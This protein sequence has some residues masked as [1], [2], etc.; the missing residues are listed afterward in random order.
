MILARSNLTLLQASCSS[1]L[2]GCGQ[3]GQVLFN[4]TRRLEG[5]AS[6]L[7]LER[8]S[9]SRCIS[10]FGISPSSLEISDEARFKCRYIQL[11]TPTQFGS[12]RGPLHMKLIIKLSLN[13]VPQEIVYSFF[14]AGHF[15][16]WQSKP[17]LF[18]KVRI[19]YLFHA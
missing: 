15:S 18:P 14:L 1:A 13:T 12:S 2:R 8:T 6:W 19:T 4:V 3:F 7:S 10:Y 11:P 9:V 17:N 16:T 5:C